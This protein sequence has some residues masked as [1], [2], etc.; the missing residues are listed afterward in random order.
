MLQKHI[1]GDLG[2]KSPAS[3]LMESILRLL[4]IEEEHL[5]SLSNLASSPD[6]EHLP[7]LNMGSCDSKGIRE[8]L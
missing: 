2:I 5:P 8:A 3:G 4:G 7:A 1:L 6:S